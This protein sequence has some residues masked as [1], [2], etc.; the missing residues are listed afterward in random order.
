MHQ[1]DSIRNSANS[2]PK[3]WTP[4]MCLHIESI[5]EKNI[6]NVCLWSFCGHCINNIA[7][8]R[9]TKL[10]LCLQYSLGRKIWWFI[11]RGQLLTVQLLRTGVLPKWWCAEDCRHTLAI[12]DPFLASNM[13]PLSTSEDDLK[14]YHVYHSYHI[15]YWTWH[16][17]LYYIYIRTDAAYPSFILIHCSYSCSNPCSYCTLPPLSAFP[18]HLSAA[19]WRRSSEWKASRAPA[20]C[21]PVWG[22][23]NAT[24][25]PE[26]I[27][28]LCW[29][30]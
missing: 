16:W 6:A 20:S 19:A 7:C 2:T 4:Q 26:S 27:E 13:Q 11:C 1:F 25:V 8:M 21:L 30:A 18:G 17:I 22:D 29:F 23:D 12:L 15:T 10:T 24:A 3:A 28:V 9:A 14:T 5:Q